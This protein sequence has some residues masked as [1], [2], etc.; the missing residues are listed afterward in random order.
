MLL[1][2]YEQMDLIR[3]YEET[4]YYL[5]LEG[6]MPGSIHQSHGQEACAVGM[7]YGLRKTDYMAST[8]R[9]A[10]HD[11]AKGVSVKDMMCEMFGKEDGCCKGRGGAMH[12]GDITVGAIPAN[13]IVGGNIPISTG[14]G[15]SLKM[16]KRDDVVVCFFG[17]GASNEGAFHEGLNGAAIWKLP[18]IFVCENNL[19]GASTSIKNTLNIEDIALRADSYGMPGEVVD[20]NDVLAVYAAAQRAITRARK[21][22]GPTL[23]ELKTYRI[24]GH[25]RSDGCAYRDDVEEAEWFARDPIELLKNKILKEKIADEQILADIHEKNEQI[26]NEAVDYAIEAKEPSVDDVLLNVYWEGD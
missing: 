10:G 17:D 2:M 25:S 20:G 21:G 12:T 11:I 19:Y 5:F 18:V 14:I 4:L 6:I 1:E 22:E 23:L 16:Q 13:A 24:A 9:P 15:L 8:H 3:T 26:V 7:L